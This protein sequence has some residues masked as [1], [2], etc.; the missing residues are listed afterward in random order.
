[1]EVYGPL[2]AGYASISR[3]NLREKPIVN[4]AV[5]H[6]HGKRKRNYPLHG[7]FYNFL[8]RGSSY[9]YILSKYVFKRSIYVFSINMW[10]QIT[11]NLLNRMFGKQT[12]DMQKTSSQK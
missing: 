5:Y 7:K 3:Q 12:K 1:M 8:L 10:Y 2:Y 9:F 6:V 4:T 11:Q